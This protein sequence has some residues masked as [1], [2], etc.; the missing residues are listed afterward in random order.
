MELEF[1]VL[2]GRFVRLEPV[3]SGMKEQLRALI[4]SDLD[5]WETLT[6]NPIAQGFDAYWTPLMKGIESGE[7]HAY[8][9]RRSSDNRLIGTSSFMGM[10]LAQ[11]GVE[12]GATFLHADARGGVTNPECKLLMLDRAFNSGAVRVEF[13]VDSGNQ[14]S[15]RALLRLGAGIEGLLRNRKIAWN[16]EVRDIPIFSIVEGEWPWIRERIRERLSAYGTPA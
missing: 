9:V 3:T 11:R 15:G 5:A 12:I 1:S 4:E 10:R 6:V 13:L 8:A 2:Q 14:R 7:R 16:G